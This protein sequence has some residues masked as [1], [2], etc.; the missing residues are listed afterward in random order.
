M[1][2]VATEFLFLQELSLGVLDRL[3]TRI[4]NQNRLESLDHRLLSRPILD[5]LTPFRD[6]K[7]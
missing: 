6:N 5:H 7:G 4:Y 3:D 1:V 2:L